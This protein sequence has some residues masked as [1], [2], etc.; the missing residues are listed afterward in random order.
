MARVIGSAWFEEQLARASTAEQRQ[1]QGFIAQLKRGSVTGKPLGY[2]FFR[3]KKF[4][5]K[6]LLFLFY[7]E[8][9]VILLVTITD[10]RHQ[11]HVIDQIVARLHLYREEI[12]RRFGRH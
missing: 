11:Q 10:K 2:P 7:A 8:Y 4:G 1:V 6:R 9:D 3:E 5:D 12:Q